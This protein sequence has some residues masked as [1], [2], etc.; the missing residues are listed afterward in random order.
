MLSI[1]DL[2]AGIYIVYE[3]AP[4]QVLEIH[5]LHIGRGG[6]SIQTKLKNLKTCQVLARNF[7][8]SDT[9]PEAEI[10]K[11]KVKYLYNHRNEYWFSGAD[12]KRFLLKEDT[13]GDSV[14]FLKPNSEVEAVYFLNNIL[15][16]NLPIKMDF[17]VTEAPP[18]I[19]GNTA[20]SATKNVTI[21]TGAQITAPLFIAEND[22]IR[23]NTVTGDYVE[24][25]EKV[26]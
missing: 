21:E 16:I 10:E 18:S 19:R 12:N 6:S 7:K 22:I 20:G 17:K 4:Y 8:P 5:H 11:R 25:V 23:I 13:L 2:I 14:N 9:F 26:K 1:N 24:R 15:N 3:G